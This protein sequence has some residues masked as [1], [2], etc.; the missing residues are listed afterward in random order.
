MTARDLLLVAEGRKLVE[1]G[2]LAEIREQ[3]NLSQAELAV[4]CGVSAAAVSRWEAGL[5]RPR[6]RA[7][8]R[9]AILCRTLVADLES[10]ADW[11]LIAAGSSP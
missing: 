2:R 3:A 5:R 10:A 8:K 11:S 6:G 9:L 4:A 7:A 1:D